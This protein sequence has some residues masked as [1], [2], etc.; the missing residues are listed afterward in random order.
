MFIFLQYL[1]G[2][3]LTTVF[4]DSYK[5]QL[6]AYAQIFENPGK[7]QTQETPLLTPITHIGILQFDPNKIISSDDLCIM[8]I[9]FLKDFNFE[10]LLQIIISIKIIL[11]KICTQNITIKNKIA[12]VCYSIK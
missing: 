7:T 9:D 1:N 8:M 11:T 10:K 3:F 5:Y 4:S 2:N 12:T 6:E